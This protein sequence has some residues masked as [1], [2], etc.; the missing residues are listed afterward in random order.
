[1][2]NA[3]QAMWLA[4]KALLRPV[5]QPNPD[6]ETAAL[7]NDL[8]TRINNL[9]IGPMGLGGRITSLAVHCETAPCHIASMPVGVNVQCH[10][11]RFKETVL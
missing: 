4:K 3:D 10:S 8:L 6:Q 11:A 7:E 9:G 5:A 2:S 1:M